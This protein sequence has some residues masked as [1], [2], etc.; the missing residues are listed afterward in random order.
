MSLAFTLLVVL[1]VA[2]ASFLVLLVLAQRG[3]GMGFLLGGS[4]GHG[5]LGSQAPAVITWVTAGAFA[6]FLCL[7]IVLNLMA[8]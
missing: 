1:L 2:A 5:L 3:R 8:R 4:S 6:L 7:V